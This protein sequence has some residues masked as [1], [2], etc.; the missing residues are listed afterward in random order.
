MELSSSSSDNWLNN[1]LCFGLSLFSVTH[2]SHLQNY[3]NSSAS[4]RACFLEDLKRRQLV[5]DVTLES[6]FSV[7]H[8]EITSLASKMNVRIT[9]PVVRGGDDN[10][11]AGGNWDQVE[12][13]G[14]ELAY[15]KV[16]SLEHMKSSM[17]KRTVEFA[18]IH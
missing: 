9:L 5:L 7:L 12:M 2:S 8:S 18:G 15:A 11:G 10:F 13:E 17:M 6:R 1:M 3:L 16:L 14:E 4:L